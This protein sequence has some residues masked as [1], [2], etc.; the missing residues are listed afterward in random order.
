MGFRVK[1]LAYRLVECKD[2]VSNWIT[3]EIRVNNRGRL[4]TDGEPKV[5]HGFR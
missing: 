2:R 1:F 3:I 5:P 4:G